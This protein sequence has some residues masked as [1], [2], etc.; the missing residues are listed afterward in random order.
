MMDFL[1]TQATKPK[2]NDTAK[3]TTSKNV[4]AWLGDVPLSTF[5]YTSELSQ[6][7]SVDYAEHAL[8]LGKPLLQFTGQRLIEQQWAATL[9][10]SVCNVDNE[11]ANLKTMV[12]SGKAYSLAFATG[13][14]AGEFVIN[15]LNIDFTQTINGLTLAASVSFTLKEYVNPDKEATKLREAKENATANIKRLPIDTMIE[16]T[17]STPKAT[18]VETIRHIPTAADKLPLNPLRT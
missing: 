17:W 8:I 9:N 16:P 18:D 13:E 11:I 7:V 3:N 10:A 1:P 6:S 4:F 14:L 15:G 5:V 2:T 12:E